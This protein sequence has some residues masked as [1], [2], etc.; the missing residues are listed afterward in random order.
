MSIPPE[1]AANRA[2][3]RQTDRLVQ[4]CFTARVSRYNYRIFHIEQILPLHPCQRRAHVECSGL[5]I[6]YNCYQCAHDFLR[7]LGEADGMARLNIAFPP[8]LPF[9]S[10]DIRAALFDTSQHESCRE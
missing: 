6:E 1:C 9:S 2:C 5:I 10:I 7:D 3:A 4:T 8:G